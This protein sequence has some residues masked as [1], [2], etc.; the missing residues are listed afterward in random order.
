MD[1]WALVE[2]R[3]P[4]FDLVFEMDAARAG[5][6]D[7]LAGELAEVAHLLDGRRTIRAVI[8]RS[9][10]GEFTVG[11]ALYELA[12]Q[13]LLVQVVN[14]EASRNEESDYGASTAEKALKMGLALA[15]AG[16]IDDSAREFRRVVEASPNDPT[17]R[18]QLGLLALKQGEWDD[19]VG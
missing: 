8:E 18:H 13:G 6:S 16:M 4:T 5:V 14:A 1:E 10:L 2:R 19:A 9:G 11:K 15:K 7:P 3:F 12:M 17:A